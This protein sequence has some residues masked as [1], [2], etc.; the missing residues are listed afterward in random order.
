M[1]IGDIERWEG[2]AEEIVPEL[3]QLIDLIT[4]AISPSGAK[5]DLKKTPRKEQVERYRNELK[6]NVDAWFKMINDEAAEIQQE[7]AG[8][9][10]K[11]VASAHPYHIAEA[12]IFNYAYKMEKM[13]HQEIEAAVQAAGKDVAA[14]TYPP[15][16]PEMMQ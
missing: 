10:P 8:L 3:V 12:R 7:L 14:P 2:I 15:V 11:L 4:E 1:K 6:G 16:S 13:L 9:D 5:W